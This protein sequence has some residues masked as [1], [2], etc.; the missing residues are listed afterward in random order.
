MRPEL[1]RT[2]ST[3]LS[4]VR[5]HHVAVECSCSHV[6]LVAVAPVLEKLPEGSVGDMLARVRC[7]RCNARSIVNARIVFV[8]ASEVA[9]ASAPDTDVH[10][11]KARG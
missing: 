5:W 9:M 8:G 1:P 2:F 10:L 7:A 4:D 3:R 6:A 11:P